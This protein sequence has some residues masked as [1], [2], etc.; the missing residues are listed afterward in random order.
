MHKL[1]HQRHILIGALVIL[2]LL[3]GQ[4]YPVTV[5]SQPF[6]GDYGGAP[7]GTSALY[8]GPLFAVVGAFPT[9]STSG[10]PFHL[11]TTQAWLDPTF[12]GLP[13]G[14][15][16]A[17]LDADDPLDPDGVPNLVD[18]DGGDGGIGISLQLTGIPIAAQLSFTVS[19]ALTASTDTFFINALIDLDLDGNWGG[20][21]ANGEPE[22]VVQNMQITVPAGS[23]QSI[24]T[25][26]FA[27]GSGFVVPLPS[28]L[29]LTL[30]S[31]PIVVPDWDGSGPPG[32][33]ALGETEDY[34]LPPGG[35]L[36]GQK[37][38]PALRINCP[39]RVNIPSFGAINFNC[40]IRNSG[41][42]IMPP[43]G[44]INGCINAAPAA[45]GEGFVRFSVR[46]IPPGAPPPDV[47]VTARAVPIFALNRN[48][49]RRAPGGALFNDSCW[50]IGPP[51]FANTVG[52]FTAIDF[53]IPMD[54]DPA[55][56]TILPPDPPIGFI[57]EPVPV[58]TEFTET[59]DQYFIGFVDGYGDDSRHVEQYPVGA[60]IYVKVVDP[61]ANKPGVVDEVS[62]LLVNPSVPQFTE[63]LLM[64][65]GP[66]TGVFFTPE[67]TLAEELG[68]PGEGDIL[69]ATYLDMKI[70]VYISDDDK[71]F[72]EPM[73]DPD[74]SFDEIPPAATLQVESTGIEIPRNQEFIL[75]ASLDIGETGL[76][77][78]GSIVNASSNN[79]N[80]LQVDPPEALAN[81]EGYSEFFL[82]GTETGTAVITLTTETL[83]LE[84]TVNIVEG[85]GMT[86][87]EAVAAN[88]GDPDI[89]NDED[90]LL[91]IQ[92]WI[93][94]DVFP[95]AGE[96]ISDADILNLIRLWVEGSPV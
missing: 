1:S 34:F 82:V 20:T 33:F 39:G 7:D 92:F 28:W 76:H 4:V 23:T 32:G 5:Q 91:A 84:V 47:L 65:S 79:P 55:V 10:G 26:R 94:G 19:T 41:G 3:F 8:P 56:V 86:V 44:A 14:P 22:W 73:P 52:R 54:T 58:L 88:S 13:P 29:R 31:V 2:F 81:S 36:F 37:A 9:L 61:R 70:D 89:V 18:G 17:E 51:G 27:F 63:I 87:A 25:P 85:G 71:D 95:P 69:E 60:D 96:V 12:S 50:E 40:A 74:I 45:P 21:G 59:G 42:P 78:L 15:P 62:A 46:G 16:S 90:I 43:N 24:T 30:T 48:A 68:A 64:E 49:G 93:F 53:D 11:D 83:K 66:D 67:P 72:L 80:I 38:K 35:A 77:L 75:N 6:A 57:A